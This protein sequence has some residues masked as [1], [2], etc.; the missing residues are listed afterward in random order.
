MNEQEYAGFWIRT[1]AAIIDTILM[2][3]IIIPVVTV[4]YG[5][6]YWAGESFIQGFWDVMLNYILPAIAVILFWSYKSATPGKM[7]TKLTI[8][9]AKTGRKPST[10][11]FIGRYLGYFVSTIPLLIGFIWVGFDK[12]KQGWHDK[13]S[14]TVVIRN[15]T[16]EPIKFE[17]QEANIKTTCPACNTVYN[18]PSHKIPVG[19]KAS[20]KCKKCGG[21]IVVEAKVE[22]TKP[23]TPKK[24]PFRSIEIEYPSI[25]RRYLS[26]FIDGLFVIG[27]VVLSSY[28]LQVENTKAIKIRIG[29]ILFM[30]FVYEPIFTAYFCTLGQKI[31]G[32]R[33]RKFPAGKRISLFKA[34]LRIIVKIFLGAISF[35]IIPYTECVNEN[36]T[37]L[38]LN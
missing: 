8:V 20:A 14:G 3:I 35:F 4:I 27:M 38:L 32:I 18:V 28:V 26:T 5:K 31:T 11:Q 36:E 37:R 34:Y 12:R 25:L 10:G 19:K 24:E 9:D 17:N 15:K 6:E 21:R 2:L 30:F 22:K 23:A 1:G 29:I 13:L 33:I 16:S 7:V